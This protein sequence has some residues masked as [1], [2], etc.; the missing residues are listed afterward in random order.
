MGNPGRKYE[1]NRHNV[2][3]KVVELLSRELDLSYKKRFLK[4][5][6][7]CYSEYKGN[8]IVLVKPLTYMNLSGNIFPDLLKKFKMKRENLLV[9][10]DNLDLPPGRCKFKLKGSPAAHNGLKSISGVLESSE[11]MRIFIGIG[12]P[13]HRDLVRDYVIGDPDEQEWPLYGDSYRAC[14]K[15][16]LEICDDKLDKVMNELNRKKPS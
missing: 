9:L 16:V 3:Y 13:G 2:G 11:Y 15:A 4:P 12:H 10:C 7:Y 8:R 14:A 5:Y 1:N 6:L